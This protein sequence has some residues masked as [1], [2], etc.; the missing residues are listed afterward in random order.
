LKLCLAVN[1]IH[2]CVDVANRW[3]N[4]KFQL[5]HMQKEEKEGEKL[6]FKVSNNETYKV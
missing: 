5:L 1:L 3:F 6:K 4:Q 2:V